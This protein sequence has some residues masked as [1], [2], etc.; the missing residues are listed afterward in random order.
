MVTATET[1][2]PYRVDVTAEEG[3]ILD[4]L[5]SDMD[6]KGSLDDYLPN[7]AM[8]PKVLRLPLPCPRCGKEIYVTFRG[9]SYTVHCSDENC[10]SYGVRGI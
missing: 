6:K 9:N 1:K 8:E 2:R 3:D 7:T 5:L 10:I 4:E